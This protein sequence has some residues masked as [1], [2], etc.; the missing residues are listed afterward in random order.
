MKRWQNI[1]VAL[2]L[3]SCLLLLSA[4]AQQ[5]T[6]ER[7]ENIPAL[8]DPAAIESS[9]APEETV[10]AAG[11]EAV[12]WQEPALEALVREKLGK[13][14]GEIYPSELDHIWGIELFGDTHIYFNADGGYTMYK[15]AVGPAPGDSELRNPSAIDVHLVDA[16]DNLLR[17]AEGRLLKD[18]SYSVGGQS[19]SRGSITSLADFAHFRNL[20]YLYVYK[21]NL[22]D[23]S[24]LT[25][26]HDLSELRL[27][28]NAIGD[29]TALGELRQLDSLRLPAN[30]ITDIEP[31][32]AL[33]GLSH[34]H[35]RSNEISDLSVLSAMPSL[36]WLNLVDNP[37]ESIEELRG[38]SLTTLYLDETPVSDLSPLADMTTLLSLCVANMDTDYIDFAPLA[39]L[40]KLGAL[41]AG[42]EQA[43]IVN[44]RS[45]AGLKRMT[46]LELIPSD[47]IPEED[48]QWLREQLPGCYFYL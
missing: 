35:L 13:Q 18:G 46:Q 12:E 6:A 32:R 23:L 2:L 26:L 25:V 37:I 28:D 40:D 3:L 27:T 17:D 39:G 33:S 7:T 43:E 41:C 44:I 11:E 22:N 16:A 10:V 31:L 15:D 5:E 24:G 4:C 47:N 1:R 19:Y 34:L 36:T 14:E 21:N 9:E 48:I 29:I 20:R 42:Q 45:L 30:A 8:S 38:I